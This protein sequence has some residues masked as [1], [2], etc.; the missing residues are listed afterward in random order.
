LSLWRVPVRLVRVLW[1]LCVGY[2]TI[3]VQ[4]PRLDDRQRS[5]EVQRWSRRM[6]QALGI[7]LQLEGVAPQHGPLLLVANHVSWLDILVV[8][9]ARHCR[10]VSKSEVHHWPLIGP[11]AEAGSTL[12]IERASRRDAMRVVHQ[13]ATSLGSGDI[14]A[15]FPEGTTGDGSVL[16]PF[17]A[18]LI[19]AAIS[20]HAPVM[21]L[22]LSYRQADGQPS[23]AVLYLG[24]DTL[25]GSVLK[26]IAAPHLTARVR[27]GQ[28]QD[29]Q[30]RDRRAWA[31]ELHQ[32]VQA[33]CD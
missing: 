3:R 15:I 27:F 33:L 9:A 6:L 13:M 25:V 17:H 21:P 14:L 4:F 28:P 5:E 12:F 23:R 20:A 31:Q 32:A 7:T 16:L 2:W 29:A 10:F 8:H 22:G 26:T 1:R 24:D 19:Q 11:M 30:G 18:N